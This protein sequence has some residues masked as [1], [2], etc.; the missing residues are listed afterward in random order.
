V[1]KATARL[2][3][4]LAMVA[5][6]SFLV[7]GCGGGPE[8][9]GVASLGSGTSTTTRS[10]AAAV[11]SSSSQ[12]GPTKAQLLVYA[13]CMRAHGLSAFPNPVRS[14]LGGYGFRAHMRPGGDLDPN[15]PRYQSAQ[16]ACQKDVPPSIADATPAVMAA[17]ALKWSRCMQAHGE[18]NFPEPNGQGV[19]RITNTTGIMNPNSP[20]FQR[21]EKACQMLGSSEFDLV[22][23]P[24][25]GGPAA[26]TS[27][28]L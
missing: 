1:I 27:G 11:S 15:S 22:I 21:A 23:T 17:N 25:A 28:G 3:P 24:G 7:A 5:A 18:P 19:I 14:A 16:K 12:S 13:E 6:M 10:G 8:H 2:L 9:N 20:Q 26:D 4:V